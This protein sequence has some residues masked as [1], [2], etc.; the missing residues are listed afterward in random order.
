MIHYDVGNEDGEPVRVQMIVINNTGQIVARLVDQVMNPGRYSVEWDAR[1]PDDRL[2]ADGVYY[3][4]F[5][6]G[7]VQLV[8]KAVVIR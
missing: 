5:I 7:Q 2:V 3:V 1:Y 6:A 4:R 8:E